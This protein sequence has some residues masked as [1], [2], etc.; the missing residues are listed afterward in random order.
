MKRFL[1]VAILNAT[2]FA[3]VGIDDPFCSRRRWAIDNQL[4]LSIYKQ[5]MLSSAEKTFCYAVIA[6]SVLGFVGFLY[7]QTKNKPF[8]LY[9]KAKESYD[10]IDPKLLSFFERYISDTSD[11]ADVASSIYLKPSR[12]LVDLMLA[13]EAAQRNLNPAVLDID[14][15]LLLFKEEAFVTDC[16][17]LKNKLQERLLL[18]EKLIALI[19]KHSLWSEQCLI[20]LKAEKERKAQEEKRYQEPS[21][22]RV[23]KRYTPRSVIKTTAQPKQAE[24]PRHCTAES[25]LYSTNRLDSCILYYGRKDY[26]GMKSS[27][28]S[29]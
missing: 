8:N 2:C 6:A 21:H 24:T 16:A 27:G 3:S 29:L 18:I 7:Y 23:T 4:R 17:S 1:L 11:I 5:K 28:L 9:E 26:P 25:I 13:L 10:K 22:G 20:Y 12:S 15:A 14:A 19:H